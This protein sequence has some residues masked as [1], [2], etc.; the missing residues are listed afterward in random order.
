[1]RNPFRITVR[2]GTNE[3]WVGDVGWNDFEEIDV[4]A[5]GGDS[6]M[7][8][9]GWPCY[10]GGGRQAGYDAANLTLCESLYSQGASAITAPRY[11]Y[12]HSNLVVP[13]EACPS[14]SSSISGLAFYPETGGSFPAAYQGGLFFSD[15]SRNCIWFMS[16]GSNGLPNPAAIQTF[17]S[18]AAGPVELMVG[19]TGDLFYPDFNGGTIRRI[20]PTSAP[21]DPT[22]R[23][24]ANPTSGDA[25]LTVQFDASTSSDPGGSSLTYAWDLDGD[26]AQDDSTAVAPSWQYTQA[27]PVLVTLRVTNTSG[28]TATATQL[29]TV[30]PSG[31]GTTYRDSVLADGPVGYWRLGDTSATNA[32]DSS[33]NGRVGTYETPYTLGATSLLTGDAD[34]AVAFTGGRVTLPTSLN[35]WAGDFTV[36]AWVKPSDAT[37]YAALF[38]R[39]TYNTNGFR[40]GQQGNRWA[41]GPPS[42]AARWRSRAPSVRSPLVRRITSSVSAREPPSGSMSTA[43]RLLPGQEHTW[44]PP[45]GA[46]SRPLAAGH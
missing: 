45:A 24:V 3:I 33:G 5:N 7:E 8:N 25:P 15:Y 30:N 37:R 29:I 16:K 36:E 40:L 35:P 34:P 18:G 6:V 38:S 19:P 10:E 39:E 21:Q 14:G 32:T 23:I 11:A 12:N 43:S 27:G 31:G 4:I 13:G 46:G 17:V 20:R 42:P 9:F 41:F 2:P 22:A 44:R 1:M 28:A 26:G